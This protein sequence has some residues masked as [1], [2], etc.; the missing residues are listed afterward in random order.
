MHGYHCI[1][2]QFCSPK[3]CTSNCTCQVN[4]GMGGGRGKKEKRVNIAN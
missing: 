4:Q 3:I 1:I 2:C